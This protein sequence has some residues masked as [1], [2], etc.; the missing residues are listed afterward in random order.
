MSSNLVTNFNFLS[1]FQFYSRG[2]VKKNYVK[3]ASS[4][5]LKI[6]FGGSPGLVAMGGDSCSGS[7]RF[8]SEHRILDGHFFIYN[9]CKIIY[10]NKGKRG[11]GMAQFF[12]KS[13]FAR[14]SVGLC[15]PQTG[16]L[17]NK[18]FLWLILN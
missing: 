1:F 13:I 8:E 6:F 14:K 18:T 15:L 5:A 11:P 9:C 17:P 4:A 12:Q 3:V 7:H 16:V 2:L 10:E